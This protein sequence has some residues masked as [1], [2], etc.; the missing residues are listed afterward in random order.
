[1]KSVQEKN[2]HYFI[3]KTEAKDANQAHVQLL[4]LIAS[5]IELQRCPLIDCNFVHLHHE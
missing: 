2:L 5:A 4:Q 1:M 3:V